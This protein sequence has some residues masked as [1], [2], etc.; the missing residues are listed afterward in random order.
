M[1]FS[2]LFVAVC[3]LSLLLLPSGLPTTS[4][5][6]VIV[7]D[8]CYTFDFTSV[9]GQQGWA[10][11]ALSADIA[12]GWGGGAAVFYS[13]AGW[14]LATDNWGAYWSGGTIGI[15]QAFEASIT[16]IIYQPETSDIGIRL[17]WRN[18]MSNPSY[19]QPPHVEWTGTAGNSYYFSTPFE[20]TTGLQTGLSKNGPFSTAYRLTS[21]YLEGVGTNPFPDN[22]CGDDGLIRPFS[23]ADEYIPTAPLT[24]PAM[25]DYAG[26]WDCNAGN[27]ELLPFPSCAT[28]VAQSLSLNASVMA[29]GDGVITSIAPFSDRQA[30]KT[31]EVRLLFGDKTCLY[32]LPNP[33]P[34]AAADGWVTEELDNAAFVTLELDSGDIIT[35]LVNDANRYVHVGL[36]VEAG[37]ILG[38]AIAREAASTRL[39]G[40]ISALLALLGGLGGV[41]TQIVLPD[42]PFAAGI[43]FMWRLQDGIGDVGPSRLLNDLTE[44]ADPTRACNADPRYAN[45]ITN[46]PTMLRDGDGWSSLGTVTWNTYNGAGV[47]IPAQS[48]ISQLLALNEST[49]YTVSFDIIGE[50]GGD[51]TAILQLGNLV[52]E[53]TINPLGN[54]VILQGVPVADY[55]TLTTLSLTNIGPPGFYVQGIC[56]TEGDVIPPLSCG[57][58]NPTFD[59]AITGWNVSNPTVQWRGGAAYVPKDESIL[60]L[61]TLAEGT[62]TLELDVRASLDY[63]AYTNGGGLSINVYFPDGSSDNLPL[64]ANYNLPGQPG[65]PNLPQRLT[66]NLTLASGVTGNLR[67]EPVLV[68]A[69]STI[70]GVLID[71]VCLSPGEPDSGGGPFTP[72]CDKAPIPETDEFGAWTAWHWHNQYR[73]FNCELMVFLNN[74]FKFFQDTTRTS[75]MA[76]RWFMSSINYSAGWFGTDF[77]PW[78]NGHFRNIAVGQ[79]TTINGS[80]SASIWDVLLA[81]INQVLSPIISSLQQVLSVLLW[82]LVGV[83]NVVFQVVNLV[84]VVGIKFIGIILSIFNLAS[85]VLLT[86]VNAFNA[87]PVA[88]ITILP[89]CGIDPRSHVFCLALWVLDNTILSGPGE[90]IIPLLVSIG[91]IHLLIWVVDRYR[92]LIA[93][94]G[95]L[96]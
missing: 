34:F 78:L 49:E 1:R 11:M 95:S 30:C 53:V 9:D 35:Y 2:L 91:S 48:G 12:A 20:V 8:W 42:D 68:E 82:V 52:E 16:G 65:Y 88:P 28:V 77:I 70:L 75:F 79:V 57:V 93:Q 50:I 64:E 72:V 67:F 29:A 13:G 94:I 60:Q 21:L 51:S 76:T 73:F 10:P 39:Q 45:C 24:D 38:K 26:F 18:S 89:Q 4:A 66:A 25:T 3:L 54:T 87:A 83:V 74:Q 71:R 6:Q 58:N 17:F 40:S 63:L 22:E 59:F 14:G 7:P 33:D 46:N 62:Y 86:L 56:V 23:V 69:D 55:G 44:Y 85:D 15:Q 47:T 27:L 36:R 32:F 90:F 31:N 80:S 61:V 5:Q 43:T 37:C 84:V 19:A 81:L 92:R 41:A 96:A